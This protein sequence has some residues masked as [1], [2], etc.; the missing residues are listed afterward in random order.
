MPQKFLPPRGK[1]L[2]SPD[3]RCRG[4]GLV[5]SANSVTIY[6]FS[7]VL[8]SGKKLARRLLVWLEDVGAWVTLMKRVDVTVGDYFNE[9]LFQCYIELVI[10]VFGHVLSTTKKLHLSDLVGKPR[11]LFSLSTIFC[12]R[13]SSSY[14]DE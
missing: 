8:S 14:S 11:P 12:S 2:D 5:I 1:F 13:D 9:I 10:E 3:T 7:L 4:K 6:F